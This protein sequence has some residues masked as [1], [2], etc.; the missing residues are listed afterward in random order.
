[1]TDHELTSSPLLGFTP[2]HAAAGADSS[3]AL[4]FLYSREGAV[5]ASLFVAAVG[6]TTPCHV[7][8]HC[9]APAAMS[10]LL[11][12]ARELKLPS[13]AQMRDHES[14]QPAQV[15]ARANCPR[16]IDAIASSPDKITLTTG[17]ATARS[18]MF[19]AARSNAVQAL[20][21]LQSNG[22][23]LHARAKLADNR[24]IAH[25]AAE[26]NS[27]DVLAFLG[28]DPQL[29]FMV[30]QPDVKGQT[31]GHV[32][33]FYDSD[34]AV[35]SI[36]QY[37]QRSLAALN[38]QNQTPAHLAAARNASRALCAIHAQ[39]GVAASTLGVS[40][41]PFLT[42]HNASGSWCWQMWTPAQCAAA[43]DACEALRSI[44]SFPDARA[45]LTSGEQPPAVIAAIH[46]A[47]DAIR[48]IYELGGRVAA[49]V[50]GVQA[51]VADNPTAAVAASRSGAVMVM[52]WM[53]RTGGCVRDSLLAVPQVGTPLNRSP[54]WVAVQTD[55]S[56]SVAALISYFRKSR[57]RVPRILV[58]GED[59][60]PSLVSLAT[61]NGS[62]C[63][64]DELLKVSVF[65]TAA[66]RST[67]CLEV[68]GTGQV[69]VSVAEGA[70]VLWLLAENVSAV[71]SFAACARALLRG[72]P[73]R[74]MNVARY[75]IATLPLHQVW[76]WR[77]YLDD[78]TARTL[79]PSIRLRLLRA[80]HPVP[81]R[82][83]RILTDR[84]DPLAGINQLVSEMVAQPVS[85]D[86]MYAD[87][88]ASGDGLRRE[89]ISA[90]ADYFRCPD[91]GLLEPTSNGDA[92][93]PSVH[94]GTN[95]RLAEYEQLGVLIGVACVHE[96]TLGG[97][98]LA[99]PL[100]AA[101]FG[102]GPLTDV[103]DNKSLRLLSP[104][105]ALRSID[106]SLHAS[107]YA[108]LVAATRSEWDVAGLDLTFD[109][110]VH[111][112]RVGDYVDPEL[113]DLIGPVRYENR[114]DYANA[115]ATAVV[116]G[117]HL[118]QL[119]AVRRGVLSVMGE[120]LVGGLRRLCTAEELG[121]LVCGAPEIDVGEWRAVTTYGGGYSNTT[122]VVDWLWAWA[123]RSQAN[124]AWLLAF[125]TGSRAPP[126]DGMASL[127][128]YR[129]IGQPFQITR[130][131]ELAASGES[132]AA[133]RLPIAA[134]CLN[135]LVLPEYQSYPELE[136]AFETAM[137]IGAGFDETAVS[138]AMPSPAESIA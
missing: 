113:G 32:A 30:L 26:N 47:T 18:P 57:R 53:W 116:C 39:G 52:E 88:A 82:P 6:G 24:N 109:D 43:A 92:Y 63:V 35:W 22:V 31:P 126:C 79:P 36:G 87:E 120:S 138:N 94:D 68:G 122:P 5:R 29:R 100:M 69:H 23:E 50:W 96:E 112:Q 19:F 119:S 62:A 45:T 107:Q 110:V 114:V 59:G 81:T 51:P 12:F 70:I 86:V 72:Q 101:A 124:A 33:A 97:L 85:V 42:R 91:T 11:S 95:P 134:T 102:I 74:P 121:L 44:A 84:R 105:D 66:T 20:R 77:D 137:R 128:G 21:A 136:R 75:V 58:D 27:C 108:W 37:A 98:Q 71:K 93:M 4:K 8:A 25:A 133:A 34:G 1:M 10:T 64:L 41:G 9:D 127:A 38:H 28:A 115:R 132:R 90:V 123:G 103:C 17:E 3:Q 40:S 89:W 7:A 54:I 135:R 13:P 131:S 67:I 61:L 48:T 16:V 117:P 130:S 80:S 73:S 99:V 104:G 76:G 14:L 2:A 106:A 46:G 125:V 83:V 60:L 78:D 118:R 15:A 111:G 55:R 49:T 56:D 129:D 65:Q